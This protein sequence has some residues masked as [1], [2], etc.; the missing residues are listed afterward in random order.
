MALPSPNLD[1]RRFQQLVDDAKRFVQQRCPEWT[2]HNVSDPG[3]TL[4]E[5]FAHMTDQLLYRLNR[6]PD[7]NHLAFLDLLGI[8]LFPP[9]PA[10]T[11]VTFWLSAPQP[12]PVV[13][14]E[15]TEVATDRTETEEARVFATTSDLTVVPCEFT[16]LLTEA[17]DG[18]PVERTDLVLHGQDV[19][20]FAEAPAPGDSMLV[21]LSAA[22]P[23]CAVVLRLDSRVEGVGVDPRQPPL[24]WE[25]HD[26]SEWRPCE[27]DEDTTGGLNRPGDVVLHV[28]ASHARTSLAGRRA[29]WLRC[30]VVPAEE[31]QPFYSAS[32]TVRG[33]EA[34]TVG[35][36]TQ[37]VHAETVD[38]EVLGDSGG[39]PGQRF[40]VGRPPVVADGTPFVVEVSDGAGWQEWTRVDSFGDSLPGDRHIRLDP[41]TGEV[42]FGPAVREPDGTLRHYGAV[43]PRG[44]RIRVRRYRTGGGRS[45]NVARGT[46]S[47]L[48]TSIPYVSRVENRQAAAGG[49]DGE[50]VAGARLRAPL[51]LRAQDRAVTASDYELIARQAAPSAA[52]IRCVPA[53]D[54]AEAGGVRVL[55]VPEVVADTGDRLRFEQ[56]VPPDEMLAGIAAHL[57]AR[58]AIGARLL[59]QPP[60]YQ[61]VTVV[62]RLVAAPGVPAGRLRERAQDALYRYLNPVVGGPDGDG[63]PFGRPVQTGE[64]HSVLQNV[65]GVELVDDLRLFAANPLTGERSDVGDRIDLERHALVFSY[66]HQIRVEEGR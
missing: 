13:L 53:E 54:A 9:A 62:A 11:D 44:A 5:A 58:R 19:T 32:P 4:I 37:A 16:H 8:T 14:H 64:A 12:G 46:L 50:T 17:A 51:Q 55:V 41:T 3:V 36:T 39:T 49:V 48:R 40:T 18:R 29:G 24:R 57:D 45:G 33:V 47:V 20:C 30:R 6:V 1:D 7:K 2:D 28:P 26:G 34:F 15:G 42:S 60:F 35:G 59:V 66:R 10:R 65:P 31:G 63:W 27:V 38:G 56:L 22:V 21:G 25:A 61:G 43:P 23:G 52:R